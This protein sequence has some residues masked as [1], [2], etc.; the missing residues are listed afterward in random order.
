MIQ[1][2]KI[3]YNYLENKWVYP[4]GASK[5]K[6]KSNQLPN[7]IKQIVLLHFY[8]LLNYLEKTLNKHKIYQY[9]I[10]A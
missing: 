10:K 4:F 8:Y 3:H 7:R 2:A 9:K 1:T 6:K 5:N